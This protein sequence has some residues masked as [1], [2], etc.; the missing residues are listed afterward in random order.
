MKPSSRRIGLA[1]LLAAGMGVASP[2]LAETSRLVAVATPG[3]SPVV[4]NISGDAPRVLDVHKAAAPRHPRPARRHVA[5]LHHHGHLP[6][7]A[8]P[9]LASV[10]LVE[11][12]PGPFKRRGPI[13]PMPAY[14]IDGIASA[15]TTPPPPIHCQRA[16]PDPSLP[17]PHLYREVP[18]VCAYDRD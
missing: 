17:D 3:E 10:V 1:L 2:V 8:R 9:G 11:P 13:V 18:L 12:I 4:Q 15:F 5:R 6:P 7:V 16:R 14:F